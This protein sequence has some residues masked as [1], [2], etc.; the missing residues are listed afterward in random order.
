MRIIQVI[1][2]M[3]FGGA[4]NHVLSLSLGLRAR[5]HEILVAAPAGSWIDAQC[6]A[7]GLTVETLPM[8]GVADLFSYWKLHRLIKTWRADIAH[9]HQIRPSQYV[10]IAALGTQ[11]VPVSTVHSSTA[12]KHMRRIRHLIAISEAVKENLVKHYY[13]P[14]RI[15]RV[16]NGVPD[17][18]RGERS[19]LRRELQ[20]PEEQFAVVLAGRFHRDKGQDLLVQAGQSCPDNIHFYFIGD[21]ATPFGQEVMALAGKDARFH[22]LGYRP[23]VQRILP[24]FDL[25]AA[26]SRREALSL[27]LLE[28]GAAL[29]PMV[30]MRVGGIPESVL[31][32]ETGLLVD[33]GDTAAFASVIRKLAF[34]PEMRERMGRRARARY[35]Q[36]FT[37]EQML[38]QTE[39]VY[40]RLLRAA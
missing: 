24:A 3:T 26:P 2:S 32:G 27:S 28:A 9:A 36:L 29:L 21:T 15:T 25:Y 5:G 6:R 14:E 10:G 8:R 4:E 40:Q 37:V 19:A 38:T 12:S 30:G 23:D 22:F 39:Q 7:N 31:D 11:A 18:M 1:R 35:E 17:V 33:A 13:P 16:Y 34:D 20:I